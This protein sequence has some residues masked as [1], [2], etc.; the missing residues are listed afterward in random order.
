MTFNRRAID[1]NSSK[2]CRTPGSHNP[3]KR[4]VREPWKDL[5]QRFQALAEGRP[6][7]ER[8]DLGRTRHPDTTQRPGSPEAAR[9]ARKAAQQDELRLTAQQ[10]DPFQPSFVLP[11]TPPSP[12]RLRRR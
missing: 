12:R 11:P 4:Q 1:H 2:T 7:L 3:N 8:M 10:Q 5:Q 9:R 6:P